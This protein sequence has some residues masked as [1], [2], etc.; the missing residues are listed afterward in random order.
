MMIS[1]KENSVQNRQS[2]PESTKFMTI[3]Y[4]I[5][6]LF[7]VT[8]CLSYGQSYEDLLQLPGSAIKTYYSAGSEQRAKEISE[9][10]SRTTSYVSKLVGFTPRVTLFVLDPEHWK[11][12]TEFPVYG[13]P[14]CTDDQ[15][16]VVASQDN[17]LWKS[18]I[19]PL[20][21]L[22]PELSE[23]IRRAYT[24][25]DNN[26][27]MGAFFDLLALHE[28]GHA[29]HI[30][31]GLQMQRLWMQE[32]FC[33]IMLHTYIAGN[34]PENVPALEV[35]PEM[36]VTAGTSAYQFTTLED[37]EK[38]YDKMDPRNYGWY[39]C[40]LHVAGKHIYNAGGEE[41]FVRLWNVL[42]KNKDKLDDTKLDSMLRQ[43]VSKEVADVQAKWNHGGN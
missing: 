1:D 9:R 33:N 43:N 18:F 10:C 40:R 32:L 11:K 20:G 6:V 29:F 25:G 7:T 22:P 12:Y 42:S 35:F 21:T 23:K 38:R 14:H 15:R 17:A 34:E 36:V 37:F 19:P 30:Q 24:S 13:M 39:Q 26:L 5:S 3:K 8:A 41:T 4:F 28:L 31:G 27:S 2:F 16:L